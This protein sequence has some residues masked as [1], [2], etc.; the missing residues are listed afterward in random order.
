VELESFVK[1]IDISDNIG[2]EVTINI[3]TNYNN[4]GT[5]YTDANGLELQERI[6]NY[7]PTW[8]LTN[9]EPVSGNYYPINAMI[10]FEDIATHD[11]LWV[12]NDR[13][14]GGSSVRNGEIEIMVHRRLVAD[15]DRGVGEPLNEKDRD[16]AGLRARMRHYLLF[17][18]ASLD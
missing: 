5:F 2:K 16:G 13:S 4:N 7:R 6:L 11:K 12:L 3:G 18:G 14:Q 15:D 17:N 8:N 9:E 10:G 1:P